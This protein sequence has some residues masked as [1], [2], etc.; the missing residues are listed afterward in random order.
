M[1]QIEA[2]TNYTEAVVLKLSERYGFDSVDAL[3]Y[4]RSDAALPSEKT[5]VRI[6]FLREDFIG[7]SFGQRQR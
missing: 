3:T 2:I 6:T 4:L 5:T 7:E 1:N